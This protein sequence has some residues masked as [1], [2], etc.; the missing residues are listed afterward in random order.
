MACKSKNLTIVE[1]GTTNLPAQVNPIAEFRS[2]SRFVK[3]C[4]AMVDQLKRIERLN[5]EVCPGRGSFV[6]S[7]EEFQLSDEAKHTMAQAQAMWRHFSPE[8]LY[9]EDGTLKASEISA[10]LS[11]TVGSVRITAGEAQTFNETLTVHVADIEGL[12]WPA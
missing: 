3:L 2:F 11:R 9:T 1:G 10:R 4:D 6:P 7:G 12:E 5:S 8:H